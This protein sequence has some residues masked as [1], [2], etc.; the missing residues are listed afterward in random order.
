MNQV[1]NINKFELKF[2]YFMYKY[3]KF[4]IKHNKINFD[5]VIRIQIIEKYIM[6]LRSLIMSTN[7]SFHTFT[8]K[9]SWSDMY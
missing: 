5:F 2:N 4:T 3:I 7:I 8:A 1:I 9:C 6:H